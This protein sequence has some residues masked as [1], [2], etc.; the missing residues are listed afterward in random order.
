MDSI[1]KLGIFGISKKRD[2]CV[3]CG[4]PIVAYDLLSFRVPV[5]YKE[6]LAGEIKNYIS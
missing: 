5:K 1:L 6:F 3:G 4:T 2:L